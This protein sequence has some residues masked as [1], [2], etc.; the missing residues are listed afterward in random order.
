MPMG[1]GKT[2]GLIN[3]MNTH[4]EEKF[5]FI[6]PFLSEV[7]R[8]KNACPDLEFKTPDDKYSKMT[9][10]KT[11]I[12]EN[13]NIISTH[14]LFS[15]IDSS[16][17]KLLESCNYT[18]ILDEVMEVIE[19]INYKKQDIHKLID[20]GIISIEDNGRVR[21][22]KDSYKSTGLRDSEVVKAI[23]NQNVYFIDDTLLL[24]IFNPEVFQYFNMIYVLTYLF[25]GSLMH[26]YTKLFGFGY[27]Y[28]N[29]KNKE[30]LKGKY[31]DLSFRTYAKEHI[32]IY[33]GKL[34]DIG[35]KDGSLSSTWFKA[36][37]QKNNKTI[38]RNNIRNYLRHVL[39]VNKDSVMW[40][41][42]KGFKER[43]KNFLTPKD[44]KTADFVSCNA[45]ATN[46]FSS[47]YNLVYAVNLYIHPYV[48]RYLKKNNIELEQG[49]Y[50][51][52]QMVQWI[53]RSAIRNG[54]EINIYIPSKRMRNL[55]KQYLNMEIEKERQIIFKNNT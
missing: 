10:F 55:L 34:N 5:M 47:K 53:W 14:A 22:T 39:N 50:A 41:T 9:D 16:L 19:P 40:S 51:L 30:I 35:N 48:D 1:T 38:L 43:N 6:T 28:Y 46:E 33:D 36:S 18:L 8:I 54:E 27:E 24:C 29:I 13:E 12:S 20:A 52:S 26:A 7:E 31:N 49:L 25:E 15:S 2:R 23:R 44:Y 45:R 42:F 21:A 4:K 37:S 3:Y 17:Y 32:K 11:L